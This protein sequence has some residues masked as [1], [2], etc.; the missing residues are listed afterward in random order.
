MARKAPASRDTSAET[1]VA[2]AVNRLTEMLSTIEDILVDIKGELS[3]IINNREDIKLPVPVITRMPK[4]ASDPNWGAKLA[5]LNKPET[6]AC[7]ECD[8]ASPDSLAVALH[9][10]WTNLVP[11]DGVEWNYLGVCPDCQQV[12]NLAR[13]KTNGESAVE[14]RRE[15]DHPKDTLF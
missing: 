4:R 13:Q 6:I 9:D 3:W 14:E 2:E 11:D 5:A 10:G 8:V 12:E 7:T 1:E 15:P